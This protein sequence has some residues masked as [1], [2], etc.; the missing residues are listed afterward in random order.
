VTGHLLPWAR[1]SSSW[2]S[3]GITRTQV[4]VWGN[5]PLH[6]AL[7]HLCYTLPMHPRRAGVRPTRSGKGDNMRVVP[8]SF[9][10]RYLKTDLGCAYTEEDGARLVRCQANA[11][12]FC[13]WCSLC[14]MCAVLLCLPAAGVQL[15]VGE[16]VDENEP[17]CRASRGGGELVPIGGAGMGLIRAWGSPQTRQ[18]SRMLLY[19]PRRSHQTTRETPGWRVK[20][21]LPSE[22]RHGTDLQRSA[23]PQHTCTQGIVIQLV[24]DSSHGLVHGCIPRQSCMPAK[25]CLP[26]IID[27]VN[28]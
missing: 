6:P 21:L 11:V 23:N 15:I 14:A 19:H 5:P 22:F 1:T 28:H 7:Q 20:H 24:R 13:L 17:V 18:I 3:S 27:V 25:F 4:C 16:E 10:V 2:P 9:S 26:S 8:G 12:S